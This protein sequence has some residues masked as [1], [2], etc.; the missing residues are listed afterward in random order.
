MA[1]PSYK[2]RYTVAGF[3]LITIALKKDLFIY[4]FDNLGIAPEIGEQLST[5]M[6]NGLLIAFVVWA[7]SRY[8]LQ[9]L[10]GIGRVIPAEAHLAIYPLAIILLLGSGNIMELRTVPGLEVALF[11]IAAMAIGFSEE[12]AFRGLIQAYLVRDMRS[13]QAVFIAAFLFG[14]VHY[15]NLFKYPGSVIAISKQ[16]LFA[17]AIGVYFGALVLRTGSLWLTS[18]IH[19]LIDFVFGSYEITTPAGK[20]LETSAVV[21]KSGNSID[22]LYPVSAIML[23]SGLYM[24]RS[25][26]FGGQ[27]SPAELVGE[28]AGVTGS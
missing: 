15:M 19:G 4:L 26:D 20:A 5:I 18:L 22:L 13:R 16:V 7:I 24:L 27:S 21:P 17:T 8:R 11:F 1:L 12:F 3:F 6:H 14:I 28:K 2:A 9:Q 25:V 10:S 23:F